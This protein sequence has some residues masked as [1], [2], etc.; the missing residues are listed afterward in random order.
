MIAQQGRVIALS[1]DDAVVRI[2]GR[3]GCAACDAGK[4]CGAGIFGRLLNRN[5]VAVEVPNSID[6]AIGQAVEVGIAEERF[7]ALV[8]RLYAAPLIAG[9]MGAAGGFV[10]GSKFGLAAPGLDLATLAG[11]ILA[12]ATTMAW[13]RRGLREFPLHDAVHL[14]RGLEQRSCLTEPGP[15]TAHSSGPDRTEFEKRY[16]CD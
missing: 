6:A 1:G 5:P 3:S 15:E 7:L 10:T 8:G 11:A 4:G 9:L 14:L 13:V 12:G 2:G 16:R